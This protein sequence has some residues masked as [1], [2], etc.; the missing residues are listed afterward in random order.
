MNLFELGQEQKLQKTVRVLWYPNITF[1]KDL[2]KDSYIQVVKNQ[3]KLLNEIRDD[4]WRYMILPC[5]VPS[6]QFDNV[7]Q[8]YM[9]FETYP[10]TMRSSF[11][12]DVVRKMLNNSFD[13]DLVMSHLPEHTHQLVNTLYNVTH[14]MPPVTG[15]SHWFDLKDVVAWPKDSFL[16]NITGL[17][18]YDRC[19][20]NT[21]AQKDLVIEQ[22]SET[23]NTKT[24]IKLDDILTV[25]HLGVKEEDIVDSINEN[26]EKIIVF[27]HRPD[28]Y[29]HFKEFIALTD[30]LW[31]IRQDFKVWIPLLDKPNRD[32]VVTTKF[33]K[34]GYYKELRKCYMGFSP[35]QKYGGWSV[36]TTDG[37]MN[38]VP[39]IM[40]DAE[41]YHELHNKASFF[42][43]DNDALMM[44]NT[45]LDDLP[46][47]NEEA[48]YALEHI[49]DNLI[50]KDKMVDMN[51]YMNDLLSKQKVMGDSEKFKE[52]VE[53]IKTNKQVGKKDLMDWL[54]W[55]R[56]IK[57]TPYRRAL[58][59]HPNIFDVNGSFPT[60]CWKD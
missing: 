31:E 42:S 47:R 41:Y 14:H 15:Y 51:E 27:N 4:L 43:D 12:V 19:Y 6:L 46:F 9:D 36:S 54:C 34:Q 52:I 8:W 49:R 37:M 53:F 2:E 17:L 50:Y 18:E 60:Y 10:Q 13:F 32:Y 25:Q 48:E 45:Y 33:D 16:Q 29:K 56:G 38:G 44:M 5:P 22:A 39:Y 24:I 7:T 55:G 26:P 59:N 21:Q 40:Y 30:E 28:T 57:W 11:R 58:M 35:K 20:I 23:F 1:Q 3:I